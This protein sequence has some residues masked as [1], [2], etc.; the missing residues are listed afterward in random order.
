ML[1]QLIPGWSSGLTI[2][3][4]GLS[5]RGSHQRLADAEAPKTRVG[6]TPRHHLRSLPR[7]SPTLG[8]QL[9]PPLRFR[10]RI[11]PLLRPL[12]LHFLRF[13]RETEEDN[14]HMGLSPLRRH[15]L[16]LPSDL[17]LYHARL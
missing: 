1:I 11:P 4:P 12:A 16:H 17:V 15:P 14:T 2:R 7:R 10:V 5:H 9:R 6:Q 8:G 13:V 3:P